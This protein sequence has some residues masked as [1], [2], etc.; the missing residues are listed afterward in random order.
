MANGEPAEQ[1]GRRARDT[2]RDTAI[3]ALTTAA[4]HGEISLE[5]LD[6]RIEAAS[7]ARTI[8]ELR[9]LI[10]DITQPTGGALGTPRIAQTAR[11]ATSHG[12]V[13]RLG[14]WQVPERIDLE[15]GHAASALDFRSSP[16]PAAGVDIHISAMQSSIRILLPRD[17]RIDFESLG[18][19]SSKALD[20]RRGETHLQ[21]FARIR[22]SGDLFQSTF[23]V[24]R[25][26]R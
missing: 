13:N 24:L 25:P 5:E 22:V 3:E 23:K 8:E 11:L 20:R 15:L 1:V 18:L 6:E 10:A 4:G 21:P 12:H 17:M 14:V 7:R 2:D 19:H 16:L 26:R 9:R